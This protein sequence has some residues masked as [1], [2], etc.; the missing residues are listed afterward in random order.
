MI[1]NFPVSF[2]DVDLAT[3][4]FQRDALVVKDKE[5]RPHLPVVSN[6]DTIG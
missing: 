2:Q 6:K 3:K 4:I 5:T 1:K